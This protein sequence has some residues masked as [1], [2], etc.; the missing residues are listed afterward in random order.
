MVV[1]LKAVYALVEQLYISN[2][3]TLVAISN[4]EQPLMLIK[5]VPSKLCIMCKK[6]EEI[7]LS[8]TRFGAIFPLSHA[9]AWQA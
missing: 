4:G 2:Q 5:D 6:L 9:K 1:K 8:S 3:R 7:K